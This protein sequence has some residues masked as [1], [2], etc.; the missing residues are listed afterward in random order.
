MHIKTRLTFQF[1]LIVAGILFFFSA[2][3]YYFSFTIQQNKFRDNL[4]EKAKNTANLLIDVNEVD[5]LLLKKIHQST[6]LLNEEEIVLTDSV[7]N[8]LYS[9][10][11]RYLYK[12]LMRINAEKEDIEYFSFIEKDGVYYK[13]YYKNNTYHV[14]VM[15]FDKSRQENLSHLREILFWSILISIWLSVLFA[16]LFSQKAM[17]PISRIIKNVKEINSSKLYSRLDEGN[18]K[19]E[20]AQLSITFN[21]MLADLEIAFE[22]QRDFVLNASHEMRT[23]L[24]VMIAESD[25]ILSRAQTDERYISHISNMVIDLRKLNTLLSNLLELAHINRDKSIDFSKVRIDEIIFNAI[26]QSKVKYP[27]RKIVPKIQYPDIKNELHINGN[28]GLLSIAFNNL[29][30]NAC[31]F[32]NESIIIEFIISDEFIKITILDNGIGIPSSELKDIYKPFIRAN[33]AKYISGFGI[34]LSLVAKIMELHEASMDIYSKVDQG[35][36]VQI[37]FKR[38]PE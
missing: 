27:D 38:F 37:L 8:V 35:T 5:S 33:N 4:L 31:K 23:P 32:S 17:K 26:Q 3:I 25:Y 10:N 24:A 14:F 34:G 36:E 12:K 1:T 20:I 28:E 15:A 18:K 19:D 11:I 9:N 7:F 6:I 16:Y 22:S 30:D 13:H 21:E 29:I 2:L